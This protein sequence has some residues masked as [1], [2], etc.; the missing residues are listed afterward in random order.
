MQWTREK[1]TNSNEER[2]EF[3]I[4]NCPFCPLCQSHDSTL[5]LTCQPICVDCGVGCGVGCIS[6]REKKRQSDGGEQLGGHWRKMCGATEQH[7][8]VLELLLLTQFP[9]TPNYA[10]R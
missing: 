10:L 8:P 9:F 2:H 6:V 5:I 3:R 7:S 4:K 1:G